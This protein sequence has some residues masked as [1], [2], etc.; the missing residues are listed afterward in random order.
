MS[1]ILQFY[2]LLA[3]ITTPIE[4]FDTVST[5]VVVPKISSFD[6]IP[7]KSYIIIETH[8]ERFGTFNTSV[9]WERK[10]SMVL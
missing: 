9:R 8:T 1:F 4:G 5:K 10:S 3:G 7:K 6:H 2:T